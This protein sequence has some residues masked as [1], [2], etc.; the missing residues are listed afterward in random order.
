MGQTPPDTPDSSNAD[1]AYRD[2]AAQFG[3]AIVRLAGSYEADIDR[4]RD[5]VQDIH[6][7]LWKSFAGFRQQC[8]VRSWVYRIGHNVANSYV[9]RER[10]A[11]VRNWVALEAVESLSDGRDVE[12]TV[13]TA[14]ALLAT[15][16]ATPRPGPSGYCTGHRG[17]GRGR[18]RRSRA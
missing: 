14:S 4:R 12:T 11:Q 2:A 16:S 3:D 9:L 18:P 1:R 6:V 10:R 15:Q 17:R 7:A 8:S 5:L 13:A